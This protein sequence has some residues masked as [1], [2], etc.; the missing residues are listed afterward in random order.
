[1]RRREVR[2]KVLLSMYEHE[3]R[4]PS[5][6]DICQRTGLLNG[7]VLPALKELIGSGFVVPIGAERYRMTGHGKYES[8][9]KG[10]EW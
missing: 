6:A 3:G 7:I 1:M 2:A 9:E 8:F 5:L 4:R 10:M